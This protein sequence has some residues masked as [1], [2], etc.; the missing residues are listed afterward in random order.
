MNKREKNNVTVYKIIKQ[1]KKQNVS[2]EWMM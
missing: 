2:K 1:K